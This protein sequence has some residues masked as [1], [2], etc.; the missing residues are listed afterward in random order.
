MWSY[1]FGTCLTIKR[2]VFFWLEVALVHEDELED[3]LSRYTN[4]NQN[5]EGG[6][7]ALLNKLLDGKKHT[8]KLKSSPNVCI[9]DGRLFVSF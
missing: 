7:I 2:F 9:Q 1:V 6:A 3:A 4:N 8:V 5:E